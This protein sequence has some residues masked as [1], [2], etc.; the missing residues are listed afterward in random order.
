MPGV[1][2]RRNTRPVRLALINRL[3]VGINEFNPNLVRPR[4]NALED[5][6]I[7]ACVCPVPGG[8]IDR[9]MDVS[10]PWRH[11]ERGRTKYRHD[12]QILRA[13]LNE[14]NA[15]RQP[16]GLWR[17]NDDLRRW[18]VLERPDSWRSCASARGLR[19]G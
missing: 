1:R 9:N 6:R 16:I 19:S 8:V 5:D 4:H 12:M 11:G 15:T 2:V 18:L 10:D 17:I 3:V 14:R 13:I 7:S